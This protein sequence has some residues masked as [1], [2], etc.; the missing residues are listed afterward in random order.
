MQQLSIFA[1]PVLLRVE[2]WVDLS[3]EQTFSP[4]KREQFSCGRTHAVDERSYSLKIQR[5]NRMGVEECKKRQKWTELKYHFSCVTW[6]VQ[7]ER[8]TSSVYLSFSLCPLLCWCP[9]MIFTSAREVMFLPDFVCLSVCLCVSKITQK[10]IAG[11]F[12][13]FE[14][15]SGMAQTTSDSILGVIWKE[16]WILDHFEIFVTIAFNGA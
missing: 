8:S 16:S 3:S 9:S 12:W 4:C 13:N 5:A 1:L 14:G 10:V 15:M 2:S 6:T 11:S 7:S